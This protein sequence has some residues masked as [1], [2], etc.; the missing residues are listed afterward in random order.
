MGAWRALAEL[1]PED[2][3]ATAALEACMARAGQQVELARELEQRRDAASGRGA[4][5]PIGAA[6]ARL[7]LDAGQPERAAAAWRDALAVEED[8]EAAVGAARRA[9]GDPGRP[10]GRGARRGPRAARGAQGRRRAS[11]AR[12]RAAPS[13]WP[14]P[15]RATRRRRSSRSPCSTR[16]PRGVA[17]GRRHRAPRAA[18]RP[19]GR[20]AADI[21]QALAPITPPPATSPGRP[22]RS[23]GSHTSCPETRTRASARAT[24][25][26]PP[27]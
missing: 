16:R 20:A 1:D 10:R 17:A 2:R 27:R 19:R 7:W 25:S 9:R 22:P 15:S 26:T 8:D 13:C 11:G 14:S 4:A 24:C 18:P 5:R 6:R 23:S 3:G 21:S 12:D